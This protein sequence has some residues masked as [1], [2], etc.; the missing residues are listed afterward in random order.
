MFVANPDDQPRQRMIDKLVAAGWIKRAVTIS[1][2]TPAD[3][4]AGRGNIEWT[5]EGLARTAALRAL[6]YDIEKQSTP[7][8]NEEV[9]WLKALAELAPPA[10]GLSG[11]ER[12]R[13]A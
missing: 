6:I 5:A 11:G 10:E 3:P 13:R 8:C 9:I 1:E 7:L 4:F 12:P 2:A